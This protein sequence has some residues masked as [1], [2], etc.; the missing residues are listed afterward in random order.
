MRA[1][2]TPVVREYQEAMK[3]AGHAEFSFTSLEGFIN[4][5]VLVEGLR[6]AIDN[7]PLPG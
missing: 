1:S 2:T 4:A 7:F 5:K 3:K 6:R